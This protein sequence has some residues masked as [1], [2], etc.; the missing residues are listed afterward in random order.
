MFCTEPLSRSSFAHCRFHPEI[1][2]YSAPA[3]HL[4]PRQAAAL[5]EL[6]VDFED[7]AGIEVADHDYVAALLENLPELL[8]ALLEFPFAALHVFEVLR[9]FAP[10]L[11]LQIDV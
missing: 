4:L 10:I 2:V 6:V 5:D 8:F 3:Y 1:Q 11:R 9:D 7:P